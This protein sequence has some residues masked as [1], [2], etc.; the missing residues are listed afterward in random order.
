MTSNT[1]A[2]KEA[3]NARRRE[4]AQQKKIEL[5]RKKKIELLIGYVDAIEDSQKIPERRI[6]VTKIPEGFIVTMWTKSGVRQRIVC[7]T[8]KQVEVVI[9]EMRLISL[10]LYKE[11]FPVYGW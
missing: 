2:R 9:Q 8:N 1:D 6:E 11:L 4:L 7:E 5:A 3:R 10:K